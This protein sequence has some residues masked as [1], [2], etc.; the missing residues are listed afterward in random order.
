MTDASLRSFVN[1]AES[2]KDFLKVRIRVALAVREDGAWSLWYSYTAFLSEVPESV[3]TFNLETL[4]IRALRDI[5]VFDDE[6]SVLAALNEIRDGA[7]L[8]QSDTWSAP[9]APTMKHLTFEYESLH[10]ER[11][12]GPKRLP[13]LTAA[14]HN[15]QYVTVSAARMK[16]IDQE[17]QL[18]RE[19]FDGFADLALALNTPVGFDELNKRRFSEFVLIAP[20]DLLLDN[21][22]EAHSSLKDG[23]L[24]LVLKAHPALSPDQL[25]LGVKAFRQKGVPDRFTLPSGELVRASDGLLRTKFKLP[26]SDVPLVEVFFSTSEGLL[27]KWFMVRSRFWKF[28]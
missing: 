22:N 4:S 25:K 20:I 2:W 8:L 5:Q 16:E 7:E 14:W 9:L 19:P 15:P 13:A 28:I 27:G 11:F 21:S 6:N 18:H 12:S 24:S 23:E 26:S 10:P 3:D 1:Q 17:L